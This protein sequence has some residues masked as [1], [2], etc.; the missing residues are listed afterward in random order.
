MKECF[1]ILTISGHWSW[2]REPSFQATIQGI[3]DFDIAA[4]GKQGVFEELYE[5]AQREWH[6][7][8]D[9]EGDDFSVVFY[10]LELN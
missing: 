9:M 6:T 2:R 5:E 4:L 10:S 3:K 8:Y 7:K 1:Y